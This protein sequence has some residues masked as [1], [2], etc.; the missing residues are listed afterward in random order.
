MSAHLP[1]PEPKPQPQTDQVVG[2]PV[3]LGDRLITLCGL[4]LFLA[5][6]VIARVLKV[7]PGQP[8]DADLAGD[9]GDIFKS[10]GIVV[11]SLG[12]ALPVPD[13]L[14][15]L[16]GASGSKIVAVLVA[17]GLLAAGSVLPGCATSDSGAKLAF[18]LRPDPH[19]PPPACLYVLEIDGRELHKGSVA[20]CPKVPACEQQP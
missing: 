11:A 17:G 18:R 14:K 9:L 13:A 6:L 20:E 5:G 7:P 8:G 16:L 1:E 12:A 3:T 10:F 15:R 19:R 4:L 2:K